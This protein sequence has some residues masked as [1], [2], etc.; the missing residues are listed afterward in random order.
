[1]FVIPFLLWALWHHKPQPPQPSQD[2]LLFIEHSE[3]TLNTYRDGSTEQAMEQ[4][5]ID[6][7]EAELDTL[8][9]AP[10]SGP[11]SD[12]LMAQVQRELHGLHVL[13][14]MEQRWIWV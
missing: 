6:G 1:M 2:V 9:A 13:D 3:S 4:D 7:V 8:R 14:E 12:A 5:I 11:A 10:Y